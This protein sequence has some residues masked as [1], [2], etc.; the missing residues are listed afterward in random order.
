M[1]PGVSVIALS[2]FIKRGHCGAS[3]S[4][5]YPASK[6]IE[7]CSRSVSQQPCVGWYQTLGIKR[8]MKAVVSTA[9]KIGEVEKE[10]TVKCAK[11]MN[12]G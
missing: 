1:L 8:C 12:M 4:T 7:K 10:N 5:V 11:T 9:L 6:T 3:T 2:G